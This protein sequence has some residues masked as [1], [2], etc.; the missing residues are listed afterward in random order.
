MLA[1]ISGKILHIDFTHVIVQTSSWLGYELVI[2]ELVYSKIFDLAEVSLFVYHSISEN[3]QS[4]FGFSD[5]EE[6]NVFKELIKISGVG[7]RVAQMILSLWVAR[8]KSAIANDDKKTL[9]SVK[10][11]WKKMAEKIILEFH[12][13]DW[14]ISGWNEESWETPNKV[15]SNLPRDTESQIIS[16]LTLMGYNLQK[17][18]QVLQEVPPELTTIEQILP[19]VIKKM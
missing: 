18:Q 11:V 4:L 10:W 1:H 16:T 13:K 19:Y 5:I 6:R 17:V 9:E 3:G 12:D 7:G 15:S 8:L 14:V 2:N